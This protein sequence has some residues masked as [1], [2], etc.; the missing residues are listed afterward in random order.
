MMQLTGRVAMA[1]SSKMIAKH[2]ETELNANDKEPIS[3][4][5]GAAEE[6]LQVLGAEINDSAVGGLVP[7]NAAFED[8]FD[9]DSTL[10][11]SKQW[12]PLLHDL[13]V[14]ITANA[15]IED[16][17]DNDAIRADSTRLQQLLHAFDVDIT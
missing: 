13:D 4:S 11:D 16:N 17:I 7:K 14:D 8:N 9:N 6:Q 5:Y 2:S 15:V 10:A 3:S 1:Q 12:L